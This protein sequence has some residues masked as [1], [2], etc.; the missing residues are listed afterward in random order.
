MIQEHRPEWDQAI[1]LL[2]RVH[3]LVS[4]Y[5]AE[6][7]DFLAK[8]LHRTVL[9]LVLDLGQLPAGEEIPTSVKEGL[10][11]KLG[12]LGAGL[13]VAIKLSIGSR[14]ANSELLTFVESLANQLA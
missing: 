10:V 11:R 14:E 9:E 4:N 7:S 6:E 1:E 13:Q 8:E 2:V 5:S 3:A 12:R